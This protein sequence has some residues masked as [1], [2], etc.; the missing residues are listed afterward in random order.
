MRTCFT[1]F[2]LALLTVGYALAGDT[3]YTGLGEKAGIEK[4]VGRTIDLSLADDRIGK[5]FDNTNIVRIKKL[6]TEQICVLA[7]GPCTY[8]GRDM[9]KS[10][11]HLKL[12]NFHFNALVE[13]LQTAMDENNIPFATQNELLAILAPMQRDVTAPPE[14]AK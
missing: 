13:N 12:Q 5:T 9:R 10:H 8:T 14:E 6:L 1:A 2:F 3:L 4:I 11:A 7:G